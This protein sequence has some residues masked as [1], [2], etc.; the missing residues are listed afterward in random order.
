[1]IKSLFA[2]TMVLASLLGRPLFA[3]EGD[4]IQFLRPVL[5]VTQEVSR[6][7]KGGEFLNQQGGL[8]NAWV[9]PTSG[10]LNLQIKTGGGLGLEVMLAGIYYSAPYHNDLPQN[11][12]RSLALG[13]PR[14]D[15]SYTKGDP[16]HPTLR[17]D[18]GI[19]NYKYDEFARNLGEYMFRT[20]A[21]PGII[22]TGGT[23]NYT[24]ANS[25]TVT[26][27]KVGQSL[28]I[29]SHDL[30]ASLE[31]EMTPVYDLNLTYMARTSLA[32]VVKIGAGVQ[33]ARL[34]N[35]HAY[36]VAPNTDDHMR[37]H[38][39][40]HNGKNLVGGALGAGYYNALKGGIDTLLA[41]PNLP[42]AERARLT[43]ER[44]EVD[45]AIAANEAIKT[46]ELKPQ[47]KSYTAFAIKPL[48]Y[49][50]FDPKPLFG[51]P[52]LFGAK[53]LVLYG[54]AAI[55]GVQ[56]H[57]VYYEKMSERIPMMLGFNIPMFNLL[58]V[59]S[60]EL[61][62]YK[63]RLLPTYDAPQN[64]NGRPTPFMALSENYYPTN[65]DRDNLKWSVSLE[66]S[67][68]RTFTVSAQA[69]SDHS[70]GWDWSNFGKTGWEMYTRPSEWYWSVKFGLKI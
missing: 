8:D 9:M 21:Y 34:L 12:V 45:T 68:L 2:P 29:F 43:L 48:V 38:Y 65:W 59:F 20:W 39:F 22:Q 6:V 64:L 53:D 32:N 46:G 57:P 61:E 28:G 27:L 7:V 67:F 60:V 36:T 49:I 24:G 62:Y 31:T 26:G 50:S 17:I 23:F 58:D 33:L 3:D 66:K 19:F 35:A 51:S 52:D 14:L 10:S 63:S 18:A 1:M 55:L 44:V 5:N 16:A 30:I 13:A 42:A 11:Y 69:A 4:S 15:A 41:D 56:N 70:R 54:E 25:A 40:K 37:V 47:I